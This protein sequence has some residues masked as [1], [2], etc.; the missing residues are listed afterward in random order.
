MTDF[1][2]CNVTAPDDAV[3]QRMVE[4]IREFMC[5]ASALSGDYRAAMVLIVAA[6]NAIIGLE[7]RVKELEARIAVLKGR[8][9]GK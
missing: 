4:Y 7:A 5:N 3:A 6:Q 1:R 9:D 2:E 8:A